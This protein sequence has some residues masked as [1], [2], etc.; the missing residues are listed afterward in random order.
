M[1]TTTIIARV[2]LTKMRSRCTGRTFN[3]LCLHAEAA[4]SRKT[5]DAR[6]ELPARLANETESWGSG[7]VGASALQDPRH[8]VLRPTPL[9]KPESLF[10]QTFS[11]PSNLLAHQLRS[12]ARRRACAGLRSV[13][14][15]ALKEPFPCKGIYDVYYKGL[16]VCR[17]TIL[18]S[19]CLRAPGQSIV[20]SKQLPA[21]LD[22]PAK[23]ATNICTVAFPNPPGTY[24]IGP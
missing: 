12:G 21:L 10:N 11:G 8:P 6:P 16:G 20:K 18:S 5:R 24:Y 23:A 7:H 4:L 3:V 19:R 14:Q 9:I 17:N 13:F 15:V 2:F 22:S 1:T